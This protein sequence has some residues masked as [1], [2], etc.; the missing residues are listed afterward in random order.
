MTC[1][2]ARIHGRLVVHTTV[3]TILVHDMKRMDTMSCV[4]EMP[5]E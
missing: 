5:F 4:N 3:N 2:K 1:K